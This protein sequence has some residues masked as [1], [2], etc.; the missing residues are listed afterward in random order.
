M[1][2]NIGK[3]PFLLQCCSCLLRRGLKPLQEKE[4]G[5]WGA[6]ELKKN[7]TDIQGIEAVGF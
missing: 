4:K 7:L 3:I 2:D 1:E 5:T 6:R